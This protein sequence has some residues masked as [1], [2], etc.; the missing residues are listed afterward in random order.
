MELTGSDELDRLQRFWKEA[1]LPN[2]GHYSSICL[3]RLKKIMNVE[4]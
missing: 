2:L 1:V 4:K 3:E